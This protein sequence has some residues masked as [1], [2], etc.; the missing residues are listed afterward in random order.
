M[1]TAV[2]SLAEPLACAVSA[3]RRSFTV[4]QRP[5]GLDQ[6]DVGIVG[7]GPL[8]LLALAAARQAGAGRVLVAARHEHQRQAVRRLGGEPLGEDEAELAGARPRLIVIA[9]GGRG[10]ALTQALSAVAPAGE[11]IVLG[12]L[13]E[14][15]PVP[16]RRAVMRGI[17]VSFSI[18]Y[19]GWGADSDFAHALSI[20]AREPHSFEFLLSHRFA[21][22]EV[23]RAFDRAAA[24]D[25]SF[26]A[27]V[28]PSLKSA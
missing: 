11:V 14:P 28:G 26:R 20:L 13:D 12:L 25:G 8:G 9:A 27:I 5:G 24:P 2:A 18:S 23:A 19:R 17:R 4:A 1:P 3:L 6:L 10:Q 21:L 22:T 16:A 7:A 15:Q